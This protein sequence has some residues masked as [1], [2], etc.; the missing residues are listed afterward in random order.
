LTFVSNR[1]APVGNLYLVTHAT[2]EGTMEFRLDQDDEDTRVS[3]AELRDAVAG[4]RLPT[5][6]RQI[7]G[8]TAIHIRGCNI[9]RDG[10]MLQQVSQAFGGRSSVDAPTHQQHYE[11]VGGPAGATAAGTSEVLTGYFVEQPGSVSRPMDQIR[12][13]FQAKYG[14]D[15]PE[16][17]LRRLSRNSRRVVTIRPTGIAPSPRDPAPPSGDLVQS[18]RAET[19]RADAYDWS[20]MVQRQRQRTIYWATGTRTEWRIDVDIHAQTATTD[21]RYY[22]TFTPTRPQRP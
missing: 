2:A 6:G 10:E 17:A 3:F 14:Q 7:D 20:V 9:G 11:Y 21:P 18:G 1:S 8:Q 16:A 13:A 4:G 12:A 22:G 15:L 5:A 19:T